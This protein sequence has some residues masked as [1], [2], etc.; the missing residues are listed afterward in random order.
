MQQV[1]FLAAVDFPVYMAQSYC[2]SHVNHIARWI[3]QLHRYV[4]QQKHLHAKHIMCSLAK[5]QSAFMYL[6][7]LQSLDA[8]VTY[9]L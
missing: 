4:Q 3:A 1:W 5:S 9:T 8:L 7:S 2:Q 6:Y